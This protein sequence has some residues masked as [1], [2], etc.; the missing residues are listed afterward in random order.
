[1]YFDSSRKTSTELREPLI[2]YVQTREKLLN[3]FSHAILLGTGSKRYEFVGVGLEPI[4]ME[5]NVT[6]LD[7]YRSR[8]IILNVLMHESIPGVTIPGPPR[9]WRGPEANFF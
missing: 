4:H 5:K 8:L 9:A 6:G 7:L 2:I 1:L 3:I